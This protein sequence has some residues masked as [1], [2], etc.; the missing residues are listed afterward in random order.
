MVTD[1]IFKATRKEYE[2]GSLD[3]V[4]VDPCPFTQFRL[5]FDSASQSEAQEPNACALATATSDGAPSVRM[6]LLKAFDSAGFVFFSNYLSQKGTHLSINPKAALLFYW[7]TL[8]RQVRIEGRCERTSAVDSDAYFSSRPKNAQLG[9]VV[10]KQSHVALN[11]SVIVEAYQ[12]L[13]Q[14]VGE[15]CVNRPE[16][17][18]GYRVLPERFEFWQGRESRLHDRVRYVRDGSKWRTERLWP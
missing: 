6:V 4:S 9:A 11:R 12:S 18:G 17:W 5:W 16:H 2:K 8:E 10:S 14:E 15:A 1:D 13:E 3:E 7:P